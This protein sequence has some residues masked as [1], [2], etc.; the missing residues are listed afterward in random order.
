MLTNTAI[1]RVIKIT[2]FVA[3]INSTFVGQE[4]LSNC[5]LTS[6]KNFIGF[7]SIEIFQGWRESNPQSWFWRPVV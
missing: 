4:T 1:S 6:F 3:P 7:A 5:A 2:T